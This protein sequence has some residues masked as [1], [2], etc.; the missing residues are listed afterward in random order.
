[1]RLEKHLGDAGGRTEVAVD[2]KGR[3]GIQK[4]GIDT[5]A[6]VHVGAYGVYEGHEIPQYPI[7]V[8]A[9][10]E[11]RPKVDFPGTTPSGAANTAGFERDLGGF[12][13]LGC[14]GGN[15]AS[16]MKGE[17]VRNVAVLVVWIVVVGFPFLKLALS[18]PPKFG[19]GC[20]ILLIRQANTS[21][22]L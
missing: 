12:E 2:L 8:V 19:H 21:V 4:V 13:S 9:I 17:K 7:G 16:R 15:L 20:A 3:M 1:M 14:G 5:S 10:A 18:W 22:F 6:I 11:A